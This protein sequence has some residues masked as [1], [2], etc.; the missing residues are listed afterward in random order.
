M[1]ETGVESRKKLG[2][3][4]AKIRDEDEEERESCAGGNRTH[5]LQV[6]SLAS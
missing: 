4:A 1:R 6:M 5:D 3:R 2:R